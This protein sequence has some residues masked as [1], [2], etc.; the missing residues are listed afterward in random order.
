MSRFDRYLL[1]QLFTLFGFFALILVLIYWINR[2]VRL[3]DSLIANGQS[4]LVFLEFSA[5]TL[6]NV[7]RLVLPIAGFAA[8]VFVANRLTQE[9][10]LVV[11]QAT[12]FSPV[13]LV[14]AVAVFGV[15]VTGMMLILS[16]ILVPMAGAQL[17]ERQREVSQNMTA[18][19]LTEGQFVH[20]GNGLTF[21][22]REIAP[23]G[24]LKNV[25]LA[26]QSLDTQ[27]TVY[28]AD[29]AFIES[30]G[31]D[32]T[33]LT[34]LNGMAEVK[35]MVSGR[36]A[37]SAFSKFQIDLG[38]IVSGGDADHIPLR[39]M[40]S[41]GLLR[42][43][44]AE[45]TGE[46]QAAVNLELHARTAQALLAVVA[47]M[48][49]FATLLL[50]GFSR[51]GL[52]KQILGAIFLLIVIKLIDNA[53]GARADQVPEEWPL[54]YLAVVTGIVIIAVILWRAATPTLFRR[55]GRAT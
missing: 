51:F 30:G 55:K 20:P 6:P 16:H 23:D 33:R 46:S 38:A 37:V 8:S 1:S 15:I 29:S 11:V 10:E 14:R 53:A 27:E 35:D 7:I 44:A 32:Q 36:L 18:R 5:L 17:S 9:S 39:N 13:R 54:V 49:G 19:L 12:G 21:Y 34:L 24:T 31:P 25:F 43:T 42:A 52:A 40:P 22:V 4:A 41:L 26:D 48:I 50:G 47:A 2:A 28:T 3:F 45:R